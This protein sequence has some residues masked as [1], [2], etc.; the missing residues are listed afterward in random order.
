M[1]E[2]IE[3]TLEELRPRVRVS[4][5][6][7]AQW[8]KAQHILQSGLDEWYKDFAP[9][10]RTALTSAYNAGLERAKEAIEENRGVSFT[11][12]GNAIFK[13]WNGCIDKSLAAIEKEKIESS[14]E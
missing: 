10:L 7:A 2:H 9:H 4:P 13:A 8:D 3:K 6:Q 12:D 14:P 5:W 1:N 11:G